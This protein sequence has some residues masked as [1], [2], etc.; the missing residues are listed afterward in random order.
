MKH[1]SR[2][3]ASYDGRDRATAPRAEVDDERRGARFRTSGVYLQEQLGV[4]HASWARRRRRFAELEAQT[5]KALPPAVEERRKNERS[6]ESSGMPPM[7]S[8]FPSRAIFVDLD[9]GDPWTERN[10]ESS[11]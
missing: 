2:A 4:I 6:S 10:D 5:K 11:M 9:R 8:E 3:R 7:C 1:L